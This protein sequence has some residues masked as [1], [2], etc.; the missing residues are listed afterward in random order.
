MGFG[1]QDQW[2]AGTYS[3]AELKGLM[4]NVLLRNDIFGNCPAL[5]ITVRDQ[6]GFDLAL[7]LAS[8]VLSALSM[9]SNSTYS[10]GLIQ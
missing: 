3:V 4:R 2:T 5:E 1:G 10:I 8:N 6:L 7:L 9:S